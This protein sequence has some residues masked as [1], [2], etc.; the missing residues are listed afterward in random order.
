MSAAELRC[1]TEPARRKGRTLVFSF[2]GRELRVHSAFDPEAEAERVCDGLPLKDSPLLVIVGGGLGF[3]ARAAASRPLAGIVTLEPHEAQ[4]EALQGAQIPGRV[5]RGEADQLLRELMRLRMELKHPDLVVI[6]NPAYQQVWKSWSRTLQQELPSGR[7]ESLFRRLSPSG[8]WQGKRVLVLQSGYFL[9]RECV[10]AFRE[11]D[12][13]V[14]ELPLDPG[15]AEISPS[16]DHRGVRVSKDFL[17]RLLEA[18]EAFRPEFVFCVNHIGFD[19]QGRLL[20]LLDSLRLPLAV[21]Y[22]DSPAYIL[23]EEAAVARDNTFLFCWERAWL[24]RMRARGFQHLMHLPL[25]GNAAFLQAKPD[26]LRSLSF[27]GGSN[28]SAIAKWRKDLALPLALRKE[29]LRLRSEFQRGAHGQLPE[30][31]LERKLHEFPGI[32]TWL[33]ETRLR[34]LCSLLVLE[35]TQMDRLQLL[36]RL[37]K[38]EP[39]LHGDAGWHRLDP[40]LCLKPPLDYYAGLAEHYAGSLISLNATSRQMPTALNQRAFDVPLA[41]GLVLGDWQEDLEHLFTP[42]VDCLAWQSVE[43]AEELCAELLHDAA[44]R[45]QIVSRARE[46]VLGR[47]LYRHRIADLLSCMRRELGPQG[48]GVSRPVH[49]GQS[50][51]KEVK[52]ENGNQRPGA[53]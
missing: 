49:A 8:V 26:G 38:Y 19:R 16:L 14:L 34:K 10:S 13:E 2:S 46:T 22:V 4:L 17:E 44:R 3:L 20:D 25:A 21:W 18:V 23:D 50:E 36:Q 9:L 35:A 27:V 48:S 47:H 53:G 29:Y 32:R 11:N 45:N 39:V 12:C 40:G 43:Q 30:D 5:I 37:E 6:H 41:G 52:N 33:S 51:A 31:L 28:T 1:R 7:T 24:P 15:G 42:G